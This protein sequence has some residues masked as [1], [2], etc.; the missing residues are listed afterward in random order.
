MTKQLATC[1]F[2]TY[3]VYQTE[4][5]FIHECMADL[6]FDTLSWSKLSGSEQAD[7][8]TS[9]RHRRKSATIIDPI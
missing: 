8:L 7:L 5:Q 3:S 4:T 6:G 2:T 9:M 1:S